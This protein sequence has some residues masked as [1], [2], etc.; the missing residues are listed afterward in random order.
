MG[1]GRAG[2]AIAV[3]LRRA[4]HE[5]AA[6][7]GRGATRERA[8]TYLEGVPFLPPADAARGAELV[9]VGVPDDA[10]E[11]AVVELAQRGALRRGAWVVHLSGAMGLDALAAARPSGARPLAVHPLQTFPDVDGGIARIP[12]CWVAVT[13]ADEDGYALGEQLARDLQGNAFRLADD[14]RPLYHAAAVFAS[15]Y[16]LA[17]TAIA[18]ELFAAAGVPDPLA[19]MLPLQRASLDNA[20]RLGPAGALT[21]PA[22]RGDAGTVARN[23]AALATAAPHAVAAYVELARVALSIGERTGSL[24]AE[25]RERVEEVL[26]TWR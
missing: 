19:A 16:L 25:A 24:S 12:G 1:A 13:A 15:N 10:I 17:A 9:V 26:A 5:I 11:A 6:V 21:G 8:T 18:E 3:L 14:A 23:L 7:S 20:E 4:G 22:V 2:T